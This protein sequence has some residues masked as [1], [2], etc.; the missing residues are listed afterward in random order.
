MI[1]KVCKRN[2]AIQVNR[3]PHSSVGIFKKAYTSGIT[4][5][6]LDQSSLK[7]TTIVPPQ[8]DHIITT[9][10]KSLTKFENAKALRLSKGPP[11]YRQSRKNGS[12]ALWNSSGHFG[13]NF[14]QPNDITIACDDM[15]PL[16]PCDHAAFPVILD[17]KLRICNHICN[18][19]IK[20]SEPHIK[21]LKTKCLEEI[22]ARLSTHGAVHKMG[23]VCATKIVMMCK[24]NILRPITKLDD[25]TVFGDDLPPINEQ[26]WP[27]LSLV[28]QILKKMLIGNSRLSVFSIHF[29]VDLLSILQTP[30]QTERSNLNAIISKFYKWKTKKEDNILPKLY[31][32][33]DDYRMSKSP[34]FMVGPILS[35]MLN[36]F[37]SLTHD[38]IYLM[39]YFQKILKLFSDPKFAYFE[40]SFLKIVEFFTDESTVFSLMVVKALILHWPVICHEKEASFIRIMTDVLPKMSARDRNLFIQRIFSIY[41]RC[42]TS[43]SAKVAEAALS[44]W[45]STLM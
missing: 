29:A 37:Q 9:A 16:P 18:F 40:N 10:P 22:L 8:R 14:S 12:G 44:I 23:D 2:T 39:N 5:P 38:K 4:I 1:L 28:Y 20:S 6:Q 15:R 11:N 17:E 34:P 27:H 32:L 25:T 21:S 30:D 42:S 31:H 45:S 35:L 19:Q 24:N 43:H 3:E 26:A 7:P 13:V 33:L 36:I 41:S